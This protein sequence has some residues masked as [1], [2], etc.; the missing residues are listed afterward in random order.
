MLWLWH[1]PVAMAPIRLLDWESPYA[2]G[3]ALEKA[4]DN[5]IKN[6]NKIKKTV[7]NLTCLIIG[8]QKE[9]LEKLGNK[10]YLMR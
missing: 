2:M 3:A 5:K 1:R 10:H 4:K 7:K 9:R 8:L 6:K